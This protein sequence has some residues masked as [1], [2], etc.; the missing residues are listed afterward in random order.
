VCTTEP[1]RTRWRGEKRREENPGR[2]AGSLVTVLTEGSQLLNLLMLR[3]FQLLA[4]QTIR[5]SFRVSVNSKCLNFIRASHT[6]VLLIICVY[7]YRPMLLL[8]SAVL[9]SYS[10]ILW[11]HIRTLT[12]CL[13]RV[14]HIFSCAKS[15]SVIKIIRMLML[16]I[17]IFHSLFPLRTGPPTLL[18]NGIQGVLPPGRKVA[19]V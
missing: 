8:I 5:K 19:G 10:N 11:I 17:L 14:P 18:F 1:V 16:H 9:N 13:K 3:Q 6:V 2:P 7:L 4:V 15:L 12:N